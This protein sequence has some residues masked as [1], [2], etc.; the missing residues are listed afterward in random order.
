MGMIATYCDNLLLF[1]YDILYIVCYTSKNALLAELSRY[2]VFLLV[3]LL[4]H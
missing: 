2:F 1:G 4:H 3:M